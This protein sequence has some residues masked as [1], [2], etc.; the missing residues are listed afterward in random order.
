MEIKEVKNKETWENFFL[1]CEEKTFLQSW[2]WG[3]FQKKNKNKIWRFGV[4][5]TGNLISCILV[6]KFIAKR[7]TFFLVPHGPVVKNAARDIKLSILKTLT[8]ILIKLAR[9]E[10][11]DFIRISPIWTR[12]DENT[13][14]FKTMGFMAAP[15]HSHP[16]ASWKLNINHSENQLLS[17]MRK[18]T[19]YLIKQ[20]ERN[21][22]IE[23][24][25]SYDMH[26]VELFNK[27]HLEVVKIHK[28]VPFSLDYFQ[29]EFDSFAG[30]GEISILFAKYKG[31]FAAAS[32]V[33]FWSG[34]GFYH[35]AA[36]L[37]KYH[38]IA[39]SYLLQWTAIKEARNRGC[40][41]YDFWGYVDPKNQTRHP[42]AGPT[43]FKMGFGGQKY[44]YAMTQDYIISYKYWLSYGIEKLRKI[45]RRL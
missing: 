41:L 21:K 13:K 42:W 38:K 7:G 6:I 10:K 35:H 27:L 8:N 43:L 24:I 15:L 37:P 18:T 22:D 40:T 20:A 19:R 2:N 34:I 31:E 16:E 45:K 25:K 5:E 28:F 33:V 3:E 9:E 36:L 11:I 44:E 4:Y 23:I 17:Q 1:R 14:I 39:L 29:K 32:Y 30:D 26:N 12:N